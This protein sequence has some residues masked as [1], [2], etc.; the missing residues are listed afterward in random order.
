MP[1]GVSY[2]IPPISE[3]FVRTSLQQLST[4]KASR[5]D[6]LCTYFLKVAASYISLSFTAIL[7]LSISSGLFPNIRENSK[8]SPM[9]KAGSL[10]DR[11]NYCP[12]SVQAIAPN[13]FE[14]HI[15][16]TFYYCLSQHELL[17][18]LGFHSYHLCELSM[19]YLSDNIVDFKKVFD[20]VDHD[21]LLDKF[22]IN[23]CFHFSM[24]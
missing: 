9:H 8:V 1:C 12:I 11:S 3:N 13:I 5:L 4:G 22:C 19:A 24:A 20:L 23:G 17:L 6:E 7:N 14:C 16:R 15:H 10:F 2:C 21:T 18:Q